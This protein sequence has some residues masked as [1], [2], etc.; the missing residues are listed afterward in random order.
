MVSPTF[1]EID[2]LEIAEKIY[3]FLNE[4]DSKY[5]ILIGTDSQANYD[6]TKFVT[7]IVVHKVGKGGIYFYETTKENKIY[8]LT[9][10]IWVEAMN[11]LKM[12]T[13]LLETLRIIS[14]LDDFCLP[15]CEI[16]LDVG[17]NGKTKNLASSIQ[18]VIVSH[19]FKT[20]IKPDSYAS[21]CVADKYT[22]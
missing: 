2:I 4:K 16:H 15:N 6:S 17:T 11:S 7:A 3:S 14:K 13:K 20:K 21:S 1:G 8:S 5:E 19:G 9:E 12:A 10:R 22:K 18:G